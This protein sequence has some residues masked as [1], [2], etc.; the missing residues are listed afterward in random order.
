MNTTDNTP[1]RDPLVDAYRQASDRE[2][3]RP[4]PGVR[5][6]VLAHA[7]V[8]AQSV[9][10][11]HDR[12]VAPVSESMRKAP[13]ANES[14]SLWR[15]AAGVVLGLAAVWMYQFT[16]PGA[17]ANEAAVATA[18]AP[19]VASARSDAKEDVAKRAVADAKTA[20]PA[21][22]VAVAA[23]V[24]APQPKTAA[25]PASPTSPA[26]TTAAPSSATAA[27]AMRGKA[28][29]RTEPVRE[30]VA[31]DAAARS[32]LA[33]PS[34][35][36]ADTAVREDVLRQ[37]T[38]VAMAKTATAKAKQEATSASAQIAMAPP[39]VAAPAVA[40]PPSSVA[41]VSLGEAAVA[42]ADNARFAAAGNAEKRMAA[43]PAPAAPAPSPVPARS[44]AAAATG[45]MSAPSVEAGTSARVE[46]P[47]V[48]M[49]AAL[50]TGDL[51]ALKSAIARGANVNAKDERG[52]TALQ[53][54]R[55]RNAAEAVRLLET[56]GAR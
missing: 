23:N 7:H 9:A 22:D 8:V 25:V 1:R 40:A 5:A 33:A 34:A 31:Y 56:A 13:A 43:A 51:T 15:V 24:P 30:Q 39:P 35:N 6:A 14:S 3:A 46:A 41:G 2:G 11:A 48:S 55:E 54:A 10:S 32:Q 49:F 44:V 4:S 26:M 18:P 29:A 27:V 53:I 47:E 20:G 28:D 38:A 17:T 50:R 19:V 37:E 45:A 52:R 16:R 21:Q 12:A 42:M 36:A